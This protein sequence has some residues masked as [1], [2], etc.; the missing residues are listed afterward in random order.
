MARPRVYKTE[1]VV[2]KRTNL[3]EADSI[4]T[5]YT[6]NLGKIRAV[7][8][9][10]RRPKSKLGGHLDLITRSALLL[11]Q[12]QNL[13]IITQSQSIESFLPL[14]SDLVRIGCAMYIAE[15][16]DQFTAEHVEN[17]PVYR[18]LSDDLLWL[19]E[20]RDPDLVL[21]HFEIQLLSHLGYQ[22]EL[23]HCLECRAPIAPQRNMFSPS[24]GG[25]LCP[26]CAGVEPAARPISVD[27][28]KVMRFLL[29]NDHT[30]AKRL[31]MKSGLSHEVEQ[32]IRLYI[33]YLLEREIK[34]LEF[35]DHIR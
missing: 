26:N 9:G 20:A 31:R 3:G 12:G 8:K 10:V 18:L 29:S 21:R 27:A 30:S 13:D 32:L 22:P 25:I 24:S 33:R 6:A 11:A 23:Y 34:S 7:A 4:I 15:L 14:K 28:L 19:C 17:Y 5:L 35:L 2:L 1:A 16:L